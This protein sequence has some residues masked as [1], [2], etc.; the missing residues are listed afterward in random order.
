MK[1]LRKHLKL[2]A[3]LSLLILILGCSKSEDESTYFS[4]PNWIQGEW[5]VN[6]S[7]S[8]STERV[9]GFEFTQNDFIPIR[10]GNYRSENNFLNQISSNS[11]FAREEISSNV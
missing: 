2:I 9:T 10:F 3:R 1:P 11:V 7:S 8:P 6:S 5:T 4:P